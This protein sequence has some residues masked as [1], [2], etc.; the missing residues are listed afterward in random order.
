LLSNTY[1]I[2]SGDFITFTREE[3]ARAKERV[4]S[5]KWKAQGEL[6]LTQADKILAKWEV[7]PESDTSWYD[8]NPDRPFSETYTLWHEYNNPVRDFVR[9]AATLLRPG[10]L[11]DR[12][13]L[14]KAAQIW[15]LHV[16]ENHKFYLDHYDS[17]MEY[18]SLGGA[19]AELFCVLYDRLSDSER[20]QYSSQ[21]TECGEAVMKCQKQWLTD[22]RL[23]RMAYSNHLAIQNNGLLKLGIV[24]G[25]T[26]WV[27]NVLD[28][29]KSFSEMLAGA[30]L[31]NGLCYESS[32]HYHY[33]TLSGLFGIADTARCCPGIDRDLFR[34]KCAGGVTLKQM[35][36]APLS[37]LLPNGELPQIGDAYSERYPPLWDTHTRMYERALVEY[38]DSEY[39]WF[40]HQ[41]ENYQGS[42]FY[43][44][45]KFEEEGKPLPAHSRHRIEH[46]YVLLAS[47]RDEEYWTGKG[48]TAFITGDRSSIHNHRDALSVTVFGGGKLWVE[49]PICRPTIGHGF[50]APVQGAFNRTMLT[51]NAVIIDEQDRTGLK[52]TLPVIRFT[53]L[54]ECSES[55]MT[56]D[57]GRIYEG[58]KMRRHVA[59][60]DE[61]CLDVFEVESDTE[62]M[63]DWVM[64]PRKEG[65]ADTGLTFESAVLPDREPYS[66]LKSIE[67]AEAGDTVEMGWGQDNDRI[68]MNLSVNAEGSLYKC[69]FPRVED[70]SEGDREFFM[71]RTAGSSLVF[72]ALYQLDTG[73]AEWKIASSEKVD[74][75]EKLELRIALE[76]EGKQ[77]KH[78]FR[79]LRPVTV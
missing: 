13:D 7:F 18:A 45:D 17:G 34:E 8:E 40:L 4:Q 16:S 5:D 20:E 26:D 65:E 32:T 6:L 54:P 36:D 49:D 37:L 77:E 70:H 1:G 31:D 38:G 76:K 50:S 79:A 67:K 68:K 60:T 27:D 35:I 30:T 42:L 63:C 28:G 57:E 23:S 25:R 3:I 74:K 66:Y 15:A 33:A 10:I 2:A 44:M 71:F 9:D 14:L 51:H 55:T 59:V 75:G 72:I 53:E 48:F 78:I 61:Y 43:G 69:A 24:L 39:I 58:V 52:K 56:D 73:N 19:F 29:P 62:H 22:P 41:K 12:D 11:L 64:H 47:Q 21:L 46:G